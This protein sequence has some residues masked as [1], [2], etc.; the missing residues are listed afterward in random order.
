[1]DDETDNGI[2]KKND[3]FYSLFFFLYTLY[4]N[5]IFL[6]LHMH[7]VYSCCSTHFVLVTFVINLKQDIVFTLSIR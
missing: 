7:T 4:K 5:G 1:M 3:L 6:Y 2:K